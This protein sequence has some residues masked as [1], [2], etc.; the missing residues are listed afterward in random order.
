MPFIRT[1]EDRNCRR[2]DVRFRPRD[3]KQTYCSKGCY[4]GRNADALAV[5]AAEGC[6]RLQRRKDYCGGHYARLRRYG[7]VRAHIP[8]RAR[9][10]WGSGKTIDGNGYRRIRAFGEPGADVNGFILEHR[11]VMAQ[12]IGRPLLPTETVHHRN[13]DKLDNRIENLELWAS[14]HARGQ[15]IPDL[16][17]YALEILSLYAP[18]RLR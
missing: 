9:P 14:Q 4:Y 11:L 15:A 1:L 7:D 12:A 18:E 10:N 2:C 16:V 17:A 5:C 6:D 13:G 8:L 3:A